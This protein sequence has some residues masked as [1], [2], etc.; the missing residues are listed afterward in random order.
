MP[1]PIFVEPG[2]HRVEV[3]ASGY[4][5][6]MR[7]AVLHPGTAIH[8]PM[9][10]EP[11]RVEVAP[12]PPERAPVEAKEGTKA[13]IPAPLPVVTASSTKAP[14]P[15]PARKGAAQPARE[16]VRAAV[17]LGGLGIGIAGTAAGV[18]GL[19]AA[20]AARSE[21]EANAHPLYPTTTLC[22]GGANDPCRQVYDTMNKAITFTA[23]GIAGL[24]LSAIGGGL[25]VYEVIRATPNG[26]TT[27]A[28]IS[29][30]MGPSEGALTLVGRF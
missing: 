15:I 24:T 4:A 22:A 16:P 29:V 2:S 5:S 30:K 14:D 23:V 8:I 25:V 7:V 1:D 20:G 21:A 27:N 19:M 9:R 18:A 6:D 13:P 26:T 28:R 10:L 3:T 17:I 12:P 11:I